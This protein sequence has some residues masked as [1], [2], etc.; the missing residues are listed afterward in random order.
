MS[1]TSPAQLSYDVFVSDGPAG[2]GDE[3][4]PDGSPLAWSP[5]S[6]TLIFGARDALLVDPPFTRTQIQGVGDWARVAGLRLVVVHVRHIPVLAEMSSMTIGPVRQNLDVIEAAARRAA[7]D[8]LQ[9]TGVDWEFVVRSGDPA[10]E[11]MAMAGDRPPTASVGGGRPHK[12]ALSGLAGS[13]GAALVHRFHG[14][15][16][17]VRGGD[18]RVERRERFRPALRA[19]PSQSTHSADRRAPCCRPL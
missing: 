5:L 6:S 9:G 3:R 14:S 15:V 11:L 8:A 19:A 1:A 17:V 7:E 4:M 18:P 13:V 10:H 12:A 16:L 2:A